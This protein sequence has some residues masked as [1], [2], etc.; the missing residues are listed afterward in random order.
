MALVS[1]MDLGLRV[2][3]MLKSQEATAKNGFETSAE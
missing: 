2:K 3:G 1:R